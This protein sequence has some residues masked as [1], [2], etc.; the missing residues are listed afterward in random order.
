M[1]V[2]LDVSQGGISLETPNSIETG[3]IVLATTDR[4]IKWIVSFWYKI[5]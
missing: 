2:A 1:G 3:L 5:Y 4:E